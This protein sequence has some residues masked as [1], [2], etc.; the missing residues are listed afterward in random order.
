VPPSEIIEKA[1][2][3]LRLL[4]ATIQFMLVETEVDKGTLKTKYSE[5]ISPAPIT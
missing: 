5:F 1:L 3:P 4:S 2:L